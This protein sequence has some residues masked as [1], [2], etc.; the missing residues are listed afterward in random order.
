MSSQ[1]LANG[2]KYKRLNTILIVLA[3]FVRLLI[4]TFVCVKFPFQN[5]RKI[6]TDF[7]TALFSARIR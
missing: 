6:V 5:Q 7:S 1:M 3:L 4:T 2:R